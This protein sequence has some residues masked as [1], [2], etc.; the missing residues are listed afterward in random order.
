MCRRNFSKQLYELFIFICVISLFHVVPLASEG[1]SLAKSPASA[2]AAADSSASAWVATGSLGT[3][4]A[5][6][7]ATLLNDGTVLVA[8]GYDFNNDVISTSED[9]NPSSGKWAQP[10]SLNFPRYSH[11][12]TLLS[13]GTVLV[14]GGLTGTDTPTSTSEIYNPSTQQWTTTT[15]SLNTA[16]YRHTATPLNDGTVLVAGGQDSNDNATTVCEIYTPSTQAWTTTGPL[17]T[18]VFY[19]TATLLQNGQVLVAGGLS[20]ISPYFAHADTEIYDPPL[21]TWTTTGPLYSARY[22]HT[23]TL[24]NDGTVLVTGGLGYDEAYLDSSEIY[25]PSA[26]SW[27]STFNLIVARAYHTATL[28]QNGQVLAAGGTPDG[29]SVLNES[30]IFTPGTSTSLP[31]APINVSATAGNAR[32]TVSFTPPASN[33]G[34]AITSYTVTYSG[35]QV[36]GTASP[37][38][39]LSLNNGTPYTFTVT[40]TNANGTGPPS[41]ASNSVTPGA[42]PGAPTGVTATA[43]IASASV[44]FTAPAITGGTITSYTVTSSSGPTASGSTSPITVTGLTGGAPCTFTVTATNATG[45]GPA[46]NPSGPVIPYTAPDAPTGVTATAGNASASVSFTAAADNGSAITSYTVSGGGQTASGIG[47]PITV[48]GLTNGTAYTFTV[49]A[50][51][52]AGPGPASAASNSV[53]PATTPSAPGSVTATLGTPG[54]NQATVTFTAPASNGS[55]ITSYTVTSSGGPSAL[56]SSSPITVTGLANGTAYTFTVTATNAIGTG[57]A[58]APSNSVT[59]YAIPGAPTGVAASAD[60]ALATVSF[61]APASNGSAITSYTV[62]SNPNGI[63]AS[64]GGSPITVTGLTNGT[65]Y[66]FTVIAT[67]LAGPSQASVPSNSVT[68]GVKPGPPLSVTASPGNAQATVNFSPPASSGGSS[69]SSYTVTSSGGQTASGA[70]SPVTVIGLANGTA[71]TFTVTATNVTGTGPASGPSNSVTPSTIP[72]PPLNVTAIPG[73]AQATVN[74]SP[75][76]FDGGSTITSYTVTSTTGNLTASGTGSP[77]TVT[78]LTN[79]NAYTFTVAAVNANGPGPASAPSN[80]VISSSG[81]SVPNPPAEVTALAGNAMAMVSFTPGWDGGETITGYTV[82]PVS[83]KGPGAKVKGTKSPIT[84]RGLA[85]GT[86]YTFMV[87]ATNKKGTGQAAASN[88]VIPATVPGAPTKVTALNGAASSNEATISFN[89]PAA[90]GSAITGYTVTSKP[91]G[92]E[93]TGGGSPIVVTGLTD[94]VAYTFTVTATNSDGTG[95]ASAPSNS[96]MPYTLPGA[97][98]NV[99]AKAGKADATVSFKAAATNGSAITSYTV[100]S[101]GD[102]SIS[103]TGKSSPV[104]VKGLTKG[105]AYTFTVTATNK[106]GPGPVSG[107]SNSVTAE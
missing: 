38:L 9:Y 22:V 24:L 32:A 63:T 8:G 29:S 73:N 74:F 7:T 51:N 40:A 19:H 90:N 53:T 49:I 4:R 66:T 85:N 1:S 80:T 59:P 20:E 36:S 87:T 83:S 65:P 75:P 69:I 15:G 11:T 89:A 68:P 95:K 43:G 23:A 12:A 41:A 77:I 30:E 70:A 99:T 14:T 3:A 98:S 44:S 81:P 2:R 76:A 50:T 5:Q 48:T 79:G 102:S 61:T 78:G 34:S 10:V 46:S 18:G 67:N 13:D 86:Q 17:A 82:T 96:V 93:A 107:D 28:L 92:I 26:Q 71:Y 94:G 106:A 39:V 31:G 47:S 101:P 58:S 33:G 42:L 54:S 6:H 56:G 105:T 84:V 104:T 37:I 35:G 21:K 97:P 52:A 55:A 100:T 88:P 103:V 25:D 72:G 45:T 62:T 64:G 91:G 57:S 16:R 60:N 27:S